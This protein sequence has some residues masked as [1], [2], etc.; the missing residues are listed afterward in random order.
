VHPRWSQNHA[1]FVIMALQYNLNSGAL[2]TS[3]LLLL[4]SVA[5]STG[6]LLCFY[7]NFR[8]SVYIPVKTIIGVVVGAA[9]DLQS[10]FSK[11]TSFTILILSSLHLSFFSHLL[12]FLSVVF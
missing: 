9:L 5:L 8:I 11:A 10:V 3:A 4:L 12:R 6:G 1:G 7:R 2:L